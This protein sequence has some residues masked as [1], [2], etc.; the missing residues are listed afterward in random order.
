MSK[1]FILNIRL[2]LVIVLLSIFASC[3]GKVEK[4]DN[5]PTIYSQR[6][7]Y[8]MKNIREQ[9]SFLKDLFSIGSDS[10]GQDKSNLPIN[11]YLWKASLEVISS[12]MPLSSIDSNSGII[13]SEWYNLKNKPNER[14]KISVLINSKELRADG[15]KVTIFKQIY[16]GSSW[17][18][19]QINPKIVISLERKIIQKAGEISSTEN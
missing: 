13:I 16:K 2:F 18:N 5:D 15:L 7:A 6:D 9:G 19:T 10:K 17:T 4:F 3:S 14:V 11:P 1:Y 8:R 12:T